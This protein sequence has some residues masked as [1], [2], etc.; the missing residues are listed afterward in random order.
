MSPPA[1]DSVTPGNSIIFTRYGDPPCCGHVPRRDRAPAE[2]RAKDPSHCPV[3]WSRVL[4]L[5]RMGMSLPLPT[6]PTQDY[7]VMPLRRAGTDGTYLWGCK[8]HYQG[9]GFSVTPFP[10]HRLLA[11]SQNRHEISASSTSPHWRCCSLQGEGRIRNGLGSGE[12][13]LTC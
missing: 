7:P 10:L 3:L 5:K 2:G 8:S 9:W 1:C 6:S 11:A 12:K 4:A 13:G